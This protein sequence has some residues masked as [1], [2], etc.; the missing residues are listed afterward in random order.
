MGAEGA[1]VT[2]P[3]GALDDRLFFTCL[4]LAQQLAQQTPPPCPTAAARCLPF[5]C[6][7]QPA[8]GLANGV[9]GEVPVSGVP[10]QGEGAKPRPQPDA[11]EFSIRTPVTPARWRDYDEASSL[12]LGWFIQLMQALQGTGLGSAGLVQLGLAR[13]RLGWALWRPWPLVG[14]LAGQ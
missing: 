8:L 2:L 13:S 7:F 6:S 11:Y 9:P 1:V 3:V 5:L 14:G 4:R 12:I 10:A